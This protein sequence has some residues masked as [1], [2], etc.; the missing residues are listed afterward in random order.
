[1]GTLAGRDW[2]YDFRE[3]DTAFTDASCAKVAARLLERYSK[4]TRL[5]LSRLDHH[6]TLIFLNKAVILEV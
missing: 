6:M 4:L 2:Y 5:I 3:I 1:M